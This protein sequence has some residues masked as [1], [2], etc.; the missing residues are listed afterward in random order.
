MNK[1]F[2]VLLPSL[3]WGPLTFSKTHLRIQVLQKVTPEI[4]YQ[5]KCGLDIEEKLRSKDTMV[6]DR[7]FHSSLKKQAKK[8]GANGVVINHFEQDGN[9]VIIK[10]EGI[11]ITYLPEELKKENIKE[12]KK[13]LKKSDLSSL[14]THLAGLDKSPFKR[15]IKDSIKLEQLLTYMAN[16][17]QLCTPGA[18]ELLK[19]YNVALS[20]LKGLKYQAL[21]CGKVLEE[22]V[23]KME[24]KVKLAKFLLK[25]TKNLVKSTRDHQDIKLLPGKLQQIRGI[26]IEV[27]DAITGACDLD[28]KSD[29]CKMEAPIDQAASALRKMRKELKQNPQ[30]SR[31]IIGNMWKQRSLM[32]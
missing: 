8:C 30:T 12:I 23:Q 14:K 28:R 16:R 22:S 26:Y 19:E 4:T 20:S 13:A 10:A 2:I 15:S 1:L 5:K 17:P 24:K 25:S 6:F 9:K 29:L 31:K 11:Q 21:F 18:L 3:L 32:I 7:D 27:S